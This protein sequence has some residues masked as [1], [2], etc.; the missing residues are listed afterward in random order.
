MTEH[1]RGEGRTRNPS[2]EMLEERFN[3][4]DAALRTIKLEGSPG[5]YARALTYTQAMI[6]D[7]HVYIVYTT[8]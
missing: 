8:N 5:K 4:V 2:F 1:F 3:P 6:I 7:L